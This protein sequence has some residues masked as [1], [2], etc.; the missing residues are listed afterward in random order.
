MINLN[1]ECLLSFSSVDIPSGWDV[2]T[3]PG[4]GKTL[5]PSLLISLSAPK[6]CAQ[7]KYIEGAVHFLG[8]RFLPPGIISKYLLRLPIYPG[9]DQVVQLSC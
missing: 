9:E 6:L 7:D 5:K 2:E 3:G 4:D 8:G 1:F